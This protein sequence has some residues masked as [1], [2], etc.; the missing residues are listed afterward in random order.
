MS[1]TAAHLGASALPV[2]DVAGLLS[3]DPDAERA[4]AEAIRAACV[5]K[6]FM[7]VTGHGIDAALRAEVFAQSAAFFARPEAEKLAVDMKLSPCNRGYEAMRAQTLEAGTP[8]DLKESFYAGRHLGPDHPAVIAGKFNHGPNQWPGGMPGFQAVMERYYD[9]LEAFGAVMMRGVALSLDLPRDYFDGFCT[10]PQCG[11][12]LIHY[13]PQ[14][15]NALPDE[16]G[17]GAHTDWGGLTILMQDDVGG[18]QVWDET[19]GWVHAPPMPDAYVVNLGDMIARW[20]NDRYRSTLHRVVN[21]TGKKRYSVP[22]FY[23]GNPDYEVACLPTCRAP[24]EAAK[25]APTTVSGHM[26]EMYAKTYAAT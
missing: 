3:G 18:L 19:L 7:Y 14:P 26:R 9:A 25:Y 16:K 12:R 20:T 11:L 2:V 10:A 1:L 8:P 23:S 5:D 22:F 21:A 13:P 4:V 15:A 17:C 24:G 6:G